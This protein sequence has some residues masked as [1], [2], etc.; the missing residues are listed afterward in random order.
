MEKNERNTDGGYKGFDI[1]SIDSDFSMILPGSGEPAKDVPGK[2]DQKVDKPSGT[3]SPFGIDLNQ[4]IAIP[5][6]EE[7]AKELGLGVI[8]S[9]SEDDDTGGKDKSADDDD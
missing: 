4:K 7:E 1:L 3:K 9:G 6:T 5:E 8:K 2:E